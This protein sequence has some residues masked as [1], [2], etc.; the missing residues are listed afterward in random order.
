[1]E[2]ITIGRI[3]CLFNQK[4]SDPRG[5]ITLRSRYTK[6]NVLIM[7]SLMQ[8]RDEWSSWQFHAEK[9]RLC[10]FHQI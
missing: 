4:P 3:Y 2:I 8:E 10:V 7:R 1:M 9:Q 5:C 6:F